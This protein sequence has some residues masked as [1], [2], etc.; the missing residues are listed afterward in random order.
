M[1]QLGEVRE[2]CLHLSSPFWDCTRK[3]KGRFASSTLKPAATLPCMPFAFPPTLFSGIVLLPVDSGQTCV[4][5]C[6]HLLC[7]CLCVSEMNFDVGNSFTVEVEFK[8]N[9]RDGVLLT[10][11]S[12]TGDIGVTLELYDGKVGWCVANNMTLSSRIPRSQLCILFLLWQKNL[13]QICSLGIR[14][15]DQNTQKVQEKNAC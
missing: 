1:K 14:R 10:V 4:L 12:L 11:G 7:V 2:S 9:E 5:M 13:K 6:D 8:T 15:K 3:M